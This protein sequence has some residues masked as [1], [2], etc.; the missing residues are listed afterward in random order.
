MLILHGY[1]C[2]ALREAVRGKLFYG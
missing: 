1:F 2:A